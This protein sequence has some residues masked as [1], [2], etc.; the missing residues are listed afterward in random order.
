MKNAKK[1]R[2]ILSLVLASSML[3]AAAG[4]SG[5]APASSGAPEAPASGEKVK[6]NMMFQVSASG[7]E[8][9]DFV[10]EKIREKY[11]DIEIVPDYVEGD[12]SN[13]A[14]KIRTLISAGGDGL[15]VW[16]DRG[17]TWVL[18]VLEA[19]A[20][21][22][23]N[24]YLDKVDGFWDTVDESAIKPH[25]DGNIYAI[26]CEEVFW[27]IILYNKEI[28]EQHGL[29]APKTVDELKNIV[30]VLK[31][32][33]IT[34]LVCAAK[35]GWPAA[36]QVEGFA[37]SMDPE[38][39]SKIMKGE[40]KFSDPP[41]LEGT[42]VIQELFSLGAYPE[43]IAMMDETEA[44]NMFY[45]GEAAMMSNGS[46][47]LPPA[48][49]ELEGNCDYFYYPAINPED[50]DSI[51]KACAGGVKDNA[52]AM[53]YSGT[54]YPE[55]ATELAVEM[56][57]NYQR[58]LYEVDQSPFVVYDAQALGWE[59]PD[60][61]PAA[62]RLADEMSKFDHS[63]PFVQDSL[64]TSAG[65]TLLMESSNKLFSNTGNYSAEDYV[66]DLDRALEEE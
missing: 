44:L 51:G 46:W 11:P 15:D 37:Y 45:S 2:S 20:A 24:D 9:P 4:C 42:K 61:D 47:G 26:P 58:Y 60:F 31:D 28:F 54:K 7:E 66:A 18:P 16:W 32:A 49:K 64:P 57:R 27:E 3:L 55:L 38:I 50:A 43:N 56:S 29:K 33:G 65:A 40:A 53:V 14:T 10:V 34:P 21:L 13:Y 5:G 48:C 35:A 19:N 41:Y 59:T 36:M 8:R 17:G 30:T 25:T 22:P 62:L 63:Y 12:E 1:L 39:T 23:L 52:G 6:I